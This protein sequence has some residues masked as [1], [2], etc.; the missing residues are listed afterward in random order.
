MKTNSV[1]NVSSKLIFWPAFLLTVAYS[2]LS[3][4][5][6]QTVATYVTQGH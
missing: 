5:E 6:I 4:E 3:S 1:G 2:F